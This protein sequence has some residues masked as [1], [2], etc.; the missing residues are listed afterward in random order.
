MCWVVVYFCIYWFGFGFICCIFCFFVCVFFMVLELVL[1]F[2]WCILGLFL[3]GGFSVVFRLDFILSCCWFDFVS[4]RVLFCL[5]WWFVFFFF[6]SFCFIL[7][8]VFCLSVLPAVF[9]FAF[10][11]PYFWLCFILAAEFCLRFWFSLAPVCRPSAVSGSV[12]PPFAVFSCFTLLL[13][14]ILGSLFV[15]FF[16]TIVLTS[17]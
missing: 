5:D 3:R 4:I 1:L 11:I 13:R 17:F 12:L 2:L 15:I 7:H 10:H 16:F 8:A 6:F 14:A 9:W